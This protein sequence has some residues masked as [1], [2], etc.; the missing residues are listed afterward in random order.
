MNFSVAPPF[1]LSAWAILLYAA[2]LILT[3]LLLWHQLRKS[4][5][6]KYEA[7]LEEDK[8]I[9][10]EEL[11]QMKMRFF[12]NVSHELR[13]PLSLITLPV[14]SLLKEHDD[15][16]LHA[17]SR[18]ASD[19]LKLVNDLLDF[20]RLEMGGEK[21]NLSTGDFGDFVSNA[22][23]T[24]REAGN[25]KNITIEFENKLKNSLMSFDASKIAKIIRNLVSNAIKYTPE[26]GYVGVSVSNPDASRVLLAVRDTG[27][28]IAGKD[29]EKIFDRF[30]RSSDAESSSGSG[31]GL[32]IVKQYAEM[33]GGSVSCESSPGEG[34]TFNVIIPV[35]EPVR[36]EAVHGPVPEEEGTESE[37]VA[38]T[39]TAQKAKILLVDDNDE[40][41]SYLSSELEASGYAVSQAREG[42]SALNLCPTAAPDIVVTDLMM[43]GMDG[44]E[45]TRRLKS[46]L[47][48]SHI[49]VVL[50]TARTAEDIRLEGYETGAD[51]YLTKPFIMDM[52][53]ARINNLVE[54]RRRRIENF[55]S[56]K[57]FS[58]SDI[59]VTTIDQKFME[60]VMGY[61]EDNMDNEDY[62]VE[63]LA[64]DVGMHRMSLYRKIQ[65]LTAMTP[66]EFIRSIR[67]KR[68]VQLMK[69]DPGLNVGEVSAMVGFGSPKLF[70]QHFKATFGV[71]PSKF[72]RQ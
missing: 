28:G 55:T 25:A 57:E 21:L 9:Q 20:R 52:L 8:R 31:I 18:N 72:R 58:P 47:E 56:P 70:A 32:N 23:E 59:A 36:A 69:G 17:I 26:G 34:S 44:L 51:A 68:A 2:F 48:T 61:L 35:A 54:E 29:L 42:E 65:S 60:K 40:F 38:A 67:L 15:P 22:I 13:T 62:S 7:K 71:T 10:K 66:S 11:D 12:F 1:W 41:R 24:L 6:R 5:A 16:R 45:F 3:V 43:P 49:P 27:C 19:L 14:E 4:S 37:D 33:M 30:Y 46:N 64:S 63:D 50:L 39:E 53:L